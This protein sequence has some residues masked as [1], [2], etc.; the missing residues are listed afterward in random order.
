MSNGS[1]TALSQADQAYQALRDLLVTLAIPPGAPISEP[2]LMERLGVGRTPLREAVHRLEGERLIKVFPRRGTFASDINLADLALLTDV[3]EELEGHA[4][5]AAA[6]RAVA[7]DRERLER[8]R[9]ELHGP[10]VRE[11]I[12]IDSQVHRTIYLAAH[13]HFLFETATQYHN[14]ALRIWHLFI[15]RLPDI[16]I[17][18]EEHEKIIHAILAGDADHART[19]A[20]DHVRSFERAVKRLV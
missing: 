20:A 15:D 8:L 2:E 19:A 16:S 17:H 5:A 9:P 13:N 18:V 12:A 7:D 14:L 3:R 11:Q 4:A 1:S 6:H 10:T